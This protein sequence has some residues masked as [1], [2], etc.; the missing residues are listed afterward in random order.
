VIQYLQSPD[1]EIVMLGQEL[2]IQFNMN[3][4][5]DGINSW[6]FTTMGWIPIRFNKLQLYAVSI[7]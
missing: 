4:E 5:F 6:I 3:V 7:W 2:G 1:M